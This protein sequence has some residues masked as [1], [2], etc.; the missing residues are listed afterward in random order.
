MPLL[1]LDVDVHNPQCLVVAIS[2]AH[3][4]ELREQYSTP[5]DACR[6]RSVQGAPP[7]VGTAPRHTRATRGQGG[8]PDHD[9]RRGAA[10]QG[11]VQQQNRRNGAASASAT[12][13]TRSIHGATTDTPSVSSTW[14]ARSWRTSTSRRPPTSSCPT[15]ETMKFTLH[16]IAGVTVSDI[17]QVSVALS[18]RPQWLP[19]STPA[20]PTTSAKIYILYIKS[21][22]T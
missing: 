22:N 15:E 5:R 4:L 19:S 7:C 14:K 6:P 11:Y 18:V 21:L 3:K 16:A 1:S 10:D 2:L 9:Q 12:N 8:Y 20:V 13:A 17:V